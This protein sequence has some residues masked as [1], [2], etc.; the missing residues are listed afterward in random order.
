MKKKLIKAAIIIICAAAV[1]FG[2]IFAVRYFRSKAAS[3]NE[4]I[5][6][7]MVTRGNIEVSIS[8]SAA[9]EPIERYE[10]IPLVNGTVTACNYEVG[11]SVNKDD[12][13]YRFDSSEISTSLKKAENDFERS[14][15]SRDETLKNKEKLTVTAPCSGVVS[16]ITVKTGDDVKS[17]FEIAKFKDTMNLEVDIPFTA[18]QIN[19]IT[20]G[21]RADISSSEH[22]SGTTGVVTHI[23]NVPTSG[24]D[25]SALYYVTIS[26]SNPG[27][28]S[29]GLKV[30]ALINGMVSP[31]SGE[32]RCME[33]KSASTEIE[34]TVSKLYIQNGDYVQKGSVIAELS[35]ETLDN[36]IKKTELEYDSAKLSLQDSYDK[37]EDY[38]ITSPINGTVITKNSKAGDTIDRSNSSVTMMVVAD[39]SKLKFDLEIDELDVVNVKEG[40]EVDITCDAVE[41]VS[42]KGYISNV[43]VEG[44]ANEGV[45][46]Y[47]AEVII[48]EPGELR[49]SMNV[50]ASVV[51]QSAENVLMLP[52]SDVKTAGNR[53]YVF[54]A[55][56]S[57]GDNDGK[58]SD[59]KGFRPDGENPSENA[60]GAER[61]GNPPENAGGMERSSNPP[62]NAGGA[63]KDGKARGNIEAPEGFKTVFVETGISNDDYIEI[64]SGLNEGEAVYPQEASLRNNNMMMGG[65]GGGPG[66]GPGDGGPPPGM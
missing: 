17:G 12:I 41:N 52:V 5:K 14:S 11:D 22:M 4:P 29:E 46:A 2:I 20:V 49:P 25:G 10:I 64:K 6:T 18:A 15:I 26:L 1:I 31:Y 28:F 36:E 21:L 27:A 59:K 61:G 33:E 24:E 34:G 19:Y 65:M 43:S 9:V 13:L 8:G 58:D 45:T 51:V 48:D 53:S 42:F 23:N 39:V 54:A 63:E 47:K 40:M 38:V 50:D 16:G 30:S 35:S 44:T 55:D 32:I 7:D 62:E 3:S 57:G 66:G 56:V 37:L 60:G